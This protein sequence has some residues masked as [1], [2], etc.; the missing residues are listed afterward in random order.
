MK[1]RKLRRLGV[2]I[3]IFVLSQ[4]SFGIDIG[5]KLLNI[6]TR[7]LKD[8]MTEAAI[9]AARN[10]RFFPAEKDGKPVSQWMT[11]EYNF[12]LY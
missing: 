1:T 3:G 2:C 6:A 9:E 5:R 8:G 7:E 12:N 10:I 4:S 11:L